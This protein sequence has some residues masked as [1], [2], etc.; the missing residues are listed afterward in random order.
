MKKIILMIVVMFISPIV[1]AQ[2]SLAKIEYSYAEEAFAKKDYKKALEHIEET[3]GLLGS[4]NARIMYLE[5]C[6]LEKTFSM[7]KNTLEDYKVYKK[8]ND[9]TSSYLSNFENDVPIEKLKVIYEI[10]K[11]FKDYTIEIENLIKGRA[12]QNEKNYDDALLYYSIACKAG[13]PEACKNLANVY[14]LKND[15]DNTKKFNDKAIDLGSINAK[16]NKGF[17]LYSGLNGYSQD[18]IKG[19][20]LME[21]TYN[22][23]FLWASGTLGRY[24]LTSD[25]EKA[26]KLYLIS[27]NQVKE[28]SSALYLYYY[29]DDLR[30]NRQL[31]KDAFE[32]VNNW[33]KINPNNGW[34]NHLKGFLLLQKLQYSAGFKYYE[35]A[36]NNGHSFS[37]NWVGIQYLKKK[38]APLYGKYGITRNKEKGKEFKSKACS[39]DPK[40]CE[41]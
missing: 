25:K 15:Y 6:S 20:K 19:V 2:N 13:N 14:S 26:K 11:E 4:T 3:K 36:C 38:N 37:C 30:I 9:F 10:Q 21:E 17:Y 29:F 28:K 12:Y 39:L 31:L 22:S 34:Y 41:K 16:Y 7:A 24:Y 5:I 18:I 40:Y 32:V 23:G 27:Y 1:F 35:K 33:L 8:L